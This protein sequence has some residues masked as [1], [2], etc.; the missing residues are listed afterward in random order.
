MLGVGTFQVGSLGEAVGERQGS[1][2]GWV[3]SHSARADWD[4]LRE[5]EDANAEM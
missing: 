2:V 5:E 3:V 1:P 4:G